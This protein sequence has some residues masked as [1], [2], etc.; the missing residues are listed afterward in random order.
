MAKQRATSKHSRAA[1]RATSPG[2]DTDKSL[3]NVKPPPADSKKPDVLAAHRSG[4]I[5]KKRRKVVLSTKARKRQEKSMDRAEAVMDRTSTKVEKSKGS[6]RVIQSRKKTWDEINRGAL[7]LVEPPPPPAA[8]AK[9]VKA[10]KNQAE[11]E[12]VAEFYA[13]DDD[14]DM[15]GAAEEG[16]KSG[17]VAVA[18]E[19]GPVEGED[20]VL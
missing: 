11:D 1:R 6:F 3:K 2:I 12:Y 7:G 17:P 15:K 10:S 5:I 9:K 20:E 4:G 14:A 8:A 13:G 18:P 19:L 16:V